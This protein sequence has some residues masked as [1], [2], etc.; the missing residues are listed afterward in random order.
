MSS[1]ASPTDL[2]AFLA[3]CRER[4]MNHMAVHLNQLPQMPARL[5][6]AMRY[7]SLL[8]GKR[9]RP[10]L[11]YASA[12]AVGNTQPMTGAD[13]AACAVE[14]MHCYS[15][16]HDD[17]PAMDDDDLRRGKPTLHRAFDEATAILAG[18]ALQSLAFQIIGEADGVAEDIRLKMMTVLAR[19]AGCEGM[20]AGQGIDLAAVGTSLELAELEN[21]HQ[22]KTGALISASVE[23]GALSAG[24]RSARTLQALGH[25]ASC[26]GL[27]FQ[28]QDDILDVTGD[29]QVLGKT[30]G[31][32][33]ARNKPTYVSLLGLDGARDKA[34]ALVAE[35]TQ[36][37][38]PLG[39]Q[40]AMLT[41]IAHYITERQH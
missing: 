2:S 14:F 4:C 13:V 19:N 36:S 23:L 6:E 21:M 1:P 27:A 11:V 35:A 28:V 34:R 5:T 26:I 31:A 3:E 22:L 17:L 40:A 32:D 37:I 8:G 33:Q 24:C 15:L 29:T 38:E 30:Q 7:S 16:A 39:D 20:I 25:Y 12:L 41:A 18:D 9:I 10:C